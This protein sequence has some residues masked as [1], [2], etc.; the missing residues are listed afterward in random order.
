MLSHP[1]MSLELDK[2]KNLK[3]QK[4]S[5]YQKI[6]NE[7]KKKVDGDNDEEMD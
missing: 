2:D 1:W 3:M 5:E 4:L 7:N 6:R